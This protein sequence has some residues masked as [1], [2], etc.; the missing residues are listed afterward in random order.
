MDL[1]WLTKSVN[2]YK[3]KKIIM[4]FHKINSIL[5]IEKNVETNWNIFSE[6]Q[7]TR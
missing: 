4:I 5:Q 6:I 7:V 1:K 2:V 3:N